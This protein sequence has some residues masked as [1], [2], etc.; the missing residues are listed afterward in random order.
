MDYYE[1]IIQFYNS[2]INII[3]ELNIEATKTLN[4]YGG[5]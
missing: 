5:F 1:N 3:T 2:F 4:K